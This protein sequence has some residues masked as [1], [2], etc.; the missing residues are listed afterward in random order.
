MKPR[1]LA[2]AWVDAF[3]RAD[4]DAIAA[5]YAEDATYLQV[6]ESPVRGR[7]AIRQVFADVFA[8]AGRILFV[9]N[10]F[11]EGDWA[12]LEWSAGQG[13]KGCG[14]FNVVEE[15]IVLQRGYGSNLVS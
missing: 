12:I 9:E 10:I 15:I 7:E 14:L 11:E 8:S 3:N 2:Q 13:L 5:F 4:A 6:G 1:Q